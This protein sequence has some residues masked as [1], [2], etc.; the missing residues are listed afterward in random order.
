[1]KI[2]IVTVVYNR[3]GTIADTMESVLVQQY[4]D[5]EYVVVDGGSTDGTVDVIKEYEPRFHG[6]MKWVS[7]KDNGI[8]DAMNKGIRMATGEVVA[9]LNSDD[10]YHRNDTLSKVAEAFAEDPDLQIVY[11]DNIWVRPDNL[12]RRIRYVKGNN[13]N[14]FTARCGVMPPHATFFV[15]KEN[16]EKHGYYDDSYKICADFERELFFLE[17]LRLKSRHLPFDF[18]TMRTGGISSSGIKGYWTSIRECHRACKEVRVITCW[19]M[20]FLKL[21]IKSVQIFQGRL[22]NIVHGALI[23]A[24]ISLLLFLLAIPCTNQMK[25]ASSSCLQQPTELR[26]R[27]APGQDA[28]LSKMYMYRLYYQTRDAQTYDEHRSFKLKDSERDQDG[29][30]RFLLPKDVCAF[31]LDGCLK[32]VDVGCKAMPAFA[33]IM[34]GDEHIEGEFKYVTDPNHAFVSV[35]Y[36]HNAILNGYLIEYF[37]LLGVVLAVVILGF[38]IYQKAEMVRRG[39]GSCEY[40]A[41]N[42][43]LPRP[44]D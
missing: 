14:W 30:Y 25:P 1:M 28:V 18:M 40:D 10:F 3:V 38:F 9:I 26:F 11:G 33:S 24:E 21:A 22:K 43:S 6:R 4:Q 20:Q 7:E 42:M 37:L 16:F 17:K 31:R 29:F 34:L 32:A 23:F 5:V 8:Y 2:S 35:Y 41:V 27:F 15:R 39:R 19:P 12:K 13:Y 44:R 36:K